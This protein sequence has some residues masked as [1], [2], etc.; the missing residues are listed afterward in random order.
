VEFFLFV[1]GAAVGGY[2]TLIGAGGG[3][4]L[5]PLLL[6]VFPKQSAASLTS[7]SL[8]FVALNALSGTLAY[9]WQRRIDVR[10]ALTLAAVTVP[11]SMV[12]AAATR[13]IPR[14]AFDVL[15]GAT[16]L[17][18]GL[19]LVRQP[20]VRARARHGEPEPPAQRLRLGLALT[21]GVGWLAGLLGIGGAPPQVVVLTHIM[22][23]PVARAMPTVQFVVLMSAIAA[24]GI[25]VL[26]GGFGASLATLV[27]LG[28]GGL[29]GA[30]LGAAL[31][32]RLSGAAL[33][34]LL[35]GALVFIGLALIGKAIA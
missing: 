9:A 21:G 14:T 11:A 13:Y 8:S 6:F 18:V 1:M 23:V 34:R 2:G 29:V 25:H 5:M 22:R 15:F 28:S 3:F 4:M 12:G 19:L 35:A 10:L 33:L 20:R 26:A 30:Q 27:F 17:V 32:R 7:L 24:A 16:L 31:S